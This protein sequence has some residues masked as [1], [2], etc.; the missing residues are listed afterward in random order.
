MTEGKRWV[1]F[2]TFF[3]LLF[4]ALHYMLRCYFKYYEAV[5]LVGSPQGEWTHH[6][7]CSDSETPCKGED[8]HPVWVMWQWTEPLWKE[9]NFV[10]S[11]WPS[12][13]GLESQQ[14]RSYYFLCFEFLL[15][16]WIS[17]RYNVPL[18]APLIWSTVGSHRLPSVA[19]VL[20]EGAK[21]SDSP[22]FD[23]IIPCKSLPLT[24]FQKAESQNRKMMYTQLEQ[25][26]AEWCCGSET[27]AILF[28]VF[29]KI[30]AVKG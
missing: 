5:F 23:V 30:T 20:F 15:F 25:E 4:F 28:L 11:K 24:E 29:Y 9:L 10:N 22:L 14:L 8:L 1:Y 7:S 13:K 19:Y 26:H 17:V 12:S 2:F 27:S 18:P 6:Q 21:D 3:F 16:Q